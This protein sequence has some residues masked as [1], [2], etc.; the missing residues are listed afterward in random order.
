MQ[1]VVIFDE[2]DN[3]VICDSAQ[4][5]VAFICKEGQVKTVVCGDVTETAIKNL[6][7][8]SQKLILNTLK[9]GEKNV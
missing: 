8:V 5:V 9:E 2:Y 6:A 4:I 7:N 3:N 1:K